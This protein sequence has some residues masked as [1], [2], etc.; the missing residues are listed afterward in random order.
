MVALSPVY[1]VNVSPTFAWH[2]THEIQKIG[3]SSLAVAAAQSGA[4]FC[5]VSLLERTCKDDALR[6]YRIILAKGLSIQT[7]QS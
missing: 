4:S 3:G 2:G 5:R 1:G 7:I 6:T